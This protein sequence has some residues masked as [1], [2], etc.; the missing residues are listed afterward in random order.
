MANSFDLCL[1]VSPIICENIIHK[2]VFGLGLDMCWEELFS[3]T[4]CL[5]L[6]EF[7]CSCVLYIS[8]Q[9][10]G[11]E[12]FPMKDGNMLTSDIDYIDVWRVRTHALCVSECTGSTDVHIEIFI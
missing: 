5:Y 1:F 10:M 9:K 11:D 8:I 2:V 12:L 6:Q 4:C 3:H 7:D